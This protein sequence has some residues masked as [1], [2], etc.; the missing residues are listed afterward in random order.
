MD[1]KHKTTARPVVNL[2]LHVLVT[3]FLHPCWNDVTDLFLPFNQEFLDFRNGF[4]RV[5]TLRAGVRAVHDGVAAVQFERVFQFV[6]SLPGGL[7]AAIGDP[8]VSLQQ[9]GRAQIAVAIPPITRAGSGTTGTHNT[10][11]Q[12]VQLA[13]FLLALQPLTVGGGRG[14]RDDPW[15]DG[16]IL[17]IKMRHVRHQVFDDL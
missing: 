12:S 2:K 13:P 4:G 15:F 17:G 1:G 7:V 5:Q 11:D 16:R 6:E 9:H 3:G 14:L 8:A 10:F